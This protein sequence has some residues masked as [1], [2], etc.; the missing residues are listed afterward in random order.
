MTLR[1]AYL[2]IA[3]LTLLVCGGAWP[4][5]AVMDIEDSGPVLQV[6]R[7]A[8]RVSNVGV[9]GNPWFDSGRSFDPSFEFPR[10]SGHELLGRAELWVAASR[11]DGSRSVSGGPTYE[12]RPSLDPDDRVRSV[13]A[14]A[15]GSRWN[16]DDDGDGRPDEDMLN[17]R[18]DDGDGRVDEDFD[19]PAQQML[20]AEYTDS[21]REAIN[22][23]Y[24]NG[25]TH[26]PLSLA[27]HQEVLGWSGGGADQIA[28]LRFVITNQG[29]EL[30]TDLRLGLYVDLDSRSSADRGG[31][32]DDF[33]ARIPYE[34]TTSEGEVLIS[35]GG[36]FSKQC[37]TRIKGEAVAVLDSRPNSGLPVGA[38]VPLSHTSDPLVLLTNDAFPGVREARAAARAP[39]SDHAFESHVFVQGLPP[40]Q[41]GPPI[42]DDQR[43]AALAGDFPEAQDLRAGQD[44]AVLVSCGPFPRL[45]PGTSVEF[46]V[47]LIAA[48]RLE[49]ISGLATAARRLE[50][51]TKFNLIADASSQAWFEG[52]TGVNGHEICFEPPAGVEFNYDPHCPSKFFGDPLM[53]PVGAVVGPGVAFEVTYR[54]GTCVWSDLDCDACTGKDGTDRAHRWSLTSLLASSPAT[55]VTPRD[56]EIAIEWDDAPEA[57]LRAGSVGDSSY[58]FEGYK[59]YRLDDWN[60]ISRLPP[61]EQWQRIGVYRADTTRGGGISLASITD[62]TV[63]ESETVNGVPHHPVGRYRV[64]DRGLHVGAD[65]HYVVTS[66]LRAHA[67]RDTLPSIVAEVESPFV[68]DFRTRVSPQTAARAGPPRAWVVPN[69]YRGHADWERPPVAGDPFTRHLDFLGLPRERSLIR[70]YTLAGDLVERIEHDGTRGDGQASWN[71]ISRNGQDVAS[72]IYLFTIDGPSGHQVGRFVIMR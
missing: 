51:G 7:F 72:G 50:R 20:T 1:R 3:A 25:E 39:A 35:A 55:R 32:L 61:P 2:R 53:I 9:I 56:G 67:P 65:Y 48:L 31:H 63:P 10:G 27:V 52:E 11:P 47:A 68:P 70:I 15:P 41:G 28:G 6:G 49:E 4:A 19:L 12:W 71:L 26:V 23:G 29:S 5:A 30:L 57:A 69:P 59:L 43:S 38:V 42:L 44:Y 22:Y 62:L 45:L 17:G 37:F 36:L 64:V 40:G 66:V 24:P 60:R 54:H 8:L 16:V 13:M 18:D 58:T 46:S 14:G 21:Q 34:M 33:I